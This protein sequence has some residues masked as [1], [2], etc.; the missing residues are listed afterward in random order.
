M[1]R[2]L[3]IHYVQYGKFEELISDPGSDLMSATVVLLNEFLGQTKLVS[4]TDHHQACGVEPTNKRI[5]AHLR[6]LVQDLRIMHNW[7]DPIILGLIGHAINSVVHSETGISPMEAKFGSSDKPWMTIADNDVITDAAPAMLQELNKDIKT[8]RDISHAYQQ[9]LVA[10][11]YD[12]SLT[13]NKYQPGDYVLFIIP[14]LHR[15]FKLHGLFL[16]PY[17]VDSHVTNTVTVRNLI[18]GAPCVT[19]INPDIGI[20]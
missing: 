10:D 11:R 8:I 4:I 16:G 7:S 19:D 17:K 18:T 5:L 9:Q 3:F 14:L 12:V 15:P 20:L 2:A 6:T 1:A 13:L